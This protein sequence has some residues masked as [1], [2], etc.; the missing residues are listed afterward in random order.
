MSKYQ[1][2]R[3]FKQYILLCADPDGVIYSL[4]DEIRKRTVIGHSFDVV[5]DK[6]DK[7]EVT[8]FI[9]G[10]G[11]DKIHSIEV[12]KV[13]KTYTID[14]EKLKQDANNLASCEEKLANLSEITR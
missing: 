4:L 14:L 1:Y 7:D 10:D 9:D 12:Q 6:D 13:E 3:T 11:S 8:V 2:I 5:V